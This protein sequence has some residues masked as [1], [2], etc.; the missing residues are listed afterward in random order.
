[1]N[2]NKIIYRVCILIII[3]FVLLFAVSAK[4]ESNAL[5]IR[6]AN[7]DVY[8]RSI[9]TGDVVGSLYKGDL[10]SVVG[11]HKRG[12]LVVEIGGEKYKVYGEYLDKYETEDINTTEKMHKSK[13]KGSK[14]Y[15]KT[16]HKIKGS[17]FDGLTFWD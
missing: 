13:S 8:V 16:K 15:N 4:S 14:V 1:M 6:K 7:T 11:K 5:D 9:E 12:Y 2:D 17:Q 3:F 10:V